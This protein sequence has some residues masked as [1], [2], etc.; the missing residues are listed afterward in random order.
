MSTPSPTG[1]N[2]RGCVKPLAIVGGSLLLIFGLASSCGSDDGEAGV[3]S[4]V[5]VTE[6]ASTVTKTTTATET[7]TT[8]AEPVETTTEEVA[9][10]AAPEPEPAPDTVMRGFAGAGAGAGIGADVDAPPPAPA[11]APAPAATYYANCA[12][13]R[14]AG[15]APLYAGS[16]G[17]SGKL[18]RDGDGVACEN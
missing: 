14:A 13:V 8:T 4:T 16:P 15:A 6:S 1:A 7:V 10:E 12:A 18:D 3:A 5:T 11:P 17:Y 2:A 9:P